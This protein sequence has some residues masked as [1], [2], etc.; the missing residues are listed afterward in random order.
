[1]KEIFL[2]HIVPCVC[3]VLMARWV[4]RDIFIASIPGDY[5]KASN[6]VLDINSRYTVLQRLNQLY[7]RKYVTH[8][9]IKAYQYHI[10]LKYFV[11]I[12]SI[13][14]FL[15][16]ICIGRICGEQTE[17]IVRRV[18]N[19]IDVVIS[20]FYLLQFDINRKTKYTRHKNDKHK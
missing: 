20:G 3:C 16:L 7:V 15:M 4:I 14:A 9:Y 13:I 1:M 6:K 18:V 10:C 5:G 2:N 8:E 12:Y 17:A 19:R 11:V